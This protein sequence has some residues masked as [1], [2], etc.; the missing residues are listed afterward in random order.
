MEE[1]TEV[2][3]GHANVAQVSCSFSGV[4][5]ACLALF[6]M[7]HKSPWLIASGCQ[8]TWYQTHPHPPKKKKKKP[9]KTPTI[10]SEQG[11]K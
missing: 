8:Q 4:G 11:R 1:A 3:C 10:S 6:T 2:S 5:S 9:K 7:A